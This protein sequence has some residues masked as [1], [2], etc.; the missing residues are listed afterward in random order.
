MLNGIASDHF[1]LSLR[2]M[3]IAA[4][5]IR[6]PST[7]MTAMRQSNART[8]ISWISNHFIVNALGAADNNAEY[9]RQW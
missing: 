6:V 2:R 5:L 1:A 4:P 8:F 7:V 3:R 9:S